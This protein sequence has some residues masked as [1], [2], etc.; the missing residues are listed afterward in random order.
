MLES[1]EGPQIMEVNSSPGLEG[2]AQATGIDVAGAIAAH[3]EEEV[4]I[5][6]IDVKQRLT[7]LETQVGGLVATEQ[8][9]Y[10]VTMQRMDRVEQRL[11]RIERRL[12]LVDDPT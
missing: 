4:L 7:V 1:E 2:I 12:D 11:D 5:P 10:A 3:I 8:S 6:D 9:H